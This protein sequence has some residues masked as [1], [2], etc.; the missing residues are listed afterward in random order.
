MQNR[1][2]TINDEKYVPGCHLGLFGWMD[3]KVAANNIIL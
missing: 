3:G 1:L 2:K